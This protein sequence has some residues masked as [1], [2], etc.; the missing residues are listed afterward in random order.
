[1]KVPGTV[2]GT[3]WCLQAVSPPLSTLIFQHPAHCAISI[4]CSEAGWADRH[5]P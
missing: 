5:S 3:W 2:Q 1:M 4:M